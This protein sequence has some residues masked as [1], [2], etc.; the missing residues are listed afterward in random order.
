MQSLRRNNFGQLCIS[1]ATIL[2]WSSKRI[3]HQYH[4][5]F[6][7]TCDQQKL[8]YIF[9]ELPRGF[10]LWNTPEDIMLNT[11]PL[12][13]EILATGSGA[14]VNPW[15]ESYQVRI[16]R[17]FRFVLKL[18]TLITSIASTLT[19]LL[20][21]MVLLALVIYVA[22]QRSCGGP[23]ATK[24]GNSKRYSFIWFRTPSNS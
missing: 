20:W 6:W 3:H 18:R 4:T 14:V 17:L 1:L 21:A 22:W 5:P 24:T 12:W 8:L 19:S 10:P 11:V 15:A 2:A 16:I 9:G 13:R 23:G 7:N